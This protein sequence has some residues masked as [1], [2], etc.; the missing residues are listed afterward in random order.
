[1]H[2]PSVRIAGRLLIL[3]E[4]FMSFSRPTTLPRRLL[5][6]VM[7]LAAVTAVPAVAFAAATSPNTT[8]PTFTN[9]SGSWN[10]E[11]SGAPFRVRA[12]ECDRVATVLATGTMTFTDVTTGVALGTASLGSG[13]PFANCSQAII[14]D[15]ESLVQGTYKIEAVYTP[16]GRTPV[17]K[18]SGS[19]AEHIQ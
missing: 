9:V 10:P 13:S 12:L 2:N 7:V 4:V 15:T 3:E 16:G 11:L 6:A 18:S 17:H 14:T 5:G 1:M 8:A 19:Y